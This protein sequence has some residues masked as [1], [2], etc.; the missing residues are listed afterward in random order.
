[1]TD[2]VRLIM[3]SIT[4]LL[5]KTIIE[6]ETPIFYFY[7]SR[8]NP[9]IC[10]LLQRCQRFRGEPGRQVEP[11]ARCPP[12]IRKAS[13]GHENH[14]PY[15]IYKIITSHHKIIKSTNLQI[16]LRRRSKIRLYALVAFRELSW[17]ILV[18][19]SGSNNHILALLPVYWS[20]NAIA[21][22]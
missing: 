20:C 12:H 11:K 5:T 10:G 9:F 18:L 4:A 13:Q 2:G 22:S 17:D 14:L 8:M 7:S 6:S 16:G 19:N 15:P 3:F 1:M 21:R